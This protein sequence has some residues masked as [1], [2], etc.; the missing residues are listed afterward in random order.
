MILIPGKQENQLCGEC[1]RP[2][3]SCECFMEPWKKG[4]GTIVPVNQEDPMKAKRPTAPT[5]EP[6][7]PEEFLHQVELVM[8]VSTPQEQRR[9]LRH[10]YG[11]AGDTYQ[12]RIPPEFRQEM[13]RIRRH[14][15]IT[16]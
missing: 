5:T 13:K 16:R 9:L 15:G 6:Y 14:Y 2:A 4:I 1:S 8:E 12:G 7:T 11:W 3:R 10:A